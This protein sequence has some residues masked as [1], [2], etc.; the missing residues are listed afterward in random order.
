MRQRGVRLVRRMFIVVVALAVGLV[1]LV[2]ISSPVQAQGRP[3]FVE[4]ELLVKFKRQ[5]PPANQ[6][7][8][9]GQAQSQLVR[10]VN[11]LDV[12][13]VKVPPQRLAQALQSYRQNPTVEFVERNPIAYAGAIPNDPLLLNGQQW[14]LQNISTNPNLHDNDID[15]PEAWTAV[16]SQQVRPT[17]ISIVDTGVL[18][19]H[20]D[21]STGNGKKQ[22]SKV[23]EARNWYDGGST[24]DVYG[25]GTHVAGIAAAYTNNGK[26]IAGVC[27]D[28][29][30]ISAKVCSNTGSCPHDRIANGV[31]WSV[32]CEDRDPPD[33][34][35]NLGRCR[36]PIRA[37][38]INMSLSGTSGSATLQQAMD[39]AADLGVTMT[40]AAGN[41]GSATP[42]YPAS[43]PTCIAVAATTTQDSRASYS[44]YGG[45]WVDVAAPGSDIRSTL[46]NGQY[47]LMS[48]TSMAAPHVAG[49]AGLLRARVVVTGEAAT[50]RDNVRSRI[51]LTTD[52]TI[53][54]VGSQF[55]HGRIN[56]CRAVGATNC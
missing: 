27:S 48:G 54:G 32:G 33:V 20:E 4:D 52:D 3:E 24:N 56:A 36:S 51:E 37:Q 45:L 8:A 28:C 47:G 49:L 43:Y 46:K 13:V 31:L 11:G 17:T 41:D 1:P 2:S 5:V 16:A 12:K 21:L 29:G 26:G 50:I 44:N 53:S 34:N 42:T 40:C 39:R 6:A 15:Y 35:G 23:R 14:A 38:V 7:A 19:T 10:E 22:V 55:A 18:S 9:H 30:L 25:H